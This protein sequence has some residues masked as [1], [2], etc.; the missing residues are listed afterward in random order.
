M[1]VK[2]LAIR[3]AV[4]VAA[5][6]VAVSMLGI[7]STLALT[8]LIPPNDFGLVAIATAIYMMI[9][10][11]TELSLSA[12]LVQM[13]DVSKAQYDASF[14]LSVLRSTFIAVIL[15]ALGPY[16]SFT[17]GDERIASLLYALAISAITIGFFNPKYVVFSRELKFHQ[18]FCMNSIGKFS[19]LLVALI[20]GYTWRSYW[21][22]VGGAFATQLVTVAISYLQVPYKPA[23]SLRHSRQI[24]SFSAWLVLS[25]AISTINL[26]LDQLLLGYF[27]GKTP[28]G[29]YA[30]GDNLANIPNREL[31]QPI[32]QVLFPSFARMKNDSARVAQAYQLSQC[33]LIA[34]AVPA[35]AG[36]AVIT[37]Q[38]VDLFLGSEWG[39][40]KIIIEII[41][42]STILQTQSGPAQSLAL[43]MGETKLLLWRDLINTMHRLPLILIGLGFFGLPGLLLGRAASCA[44]GA[45]VNMLFV[46]RLIGLNVITQLS[47]NWRTGVAGLALVVSA[48]LAKD[49]LYGFNSQSPDLLIILCMMI[50]ASVAYISSLVLLWLIS[51]RPEGFEAELVKAV[52]KIPRI[53]LL[54]RSVLKLK[55]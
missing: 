46:Q 25:Q 54:G 4:W 44:I 26:R 34:I 7:V 41:A 2:N 21:A 48:F 16:V 33:A 19:G 23:L 20:I 14:T 32:A 42:L 49:S 28:L 12:A 43:A 11:I 36:F 31:T 18:E 10:S 6:R 24:F 17:Y 53:D 15:V 22:L 51:G 9:A 8:H 39:S 40:T 30:V 1:D 55:S 50:V 38:F 27:L 47:A 3:G 45:I 29:A 5:T 13:E 37:P 35:G 52:S